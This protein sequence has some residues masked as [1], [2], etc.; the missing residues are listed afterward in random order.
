MT[1][2]LTGISIVTIYQMK[3]ELQISGKFSSPAKK[4]KKKV[5]HKIAW[6]NMMVLL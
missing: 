3:A 6:K 2:D 1:S 5:E 4:K